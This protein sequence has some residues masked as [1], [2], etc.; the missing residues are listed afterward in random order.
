MLITI[1]FKDTDELYVLGDIIDRGDEPV[2]L[3]F[4]LMERPNVFPLMG[5]HEFTFWETI[6]TV[7][8]D[9]TVD[10]FM[11]YLDE[12]GL[13]NLSIMIADGGRVTLEQYFVLSQDDKAMFLDYI[14]EFALYYELTANKK[15]FLLTHSGLLNFN[16]E[17]DIDSYE[18]D[19]YLF[20]R[21]EYNKLF[22]RDKTIIFG[23]TPTMIYPE[24]PNPGKIIKS[25]TYINIDCGCGFRDR[26]GK[27]GCLRLE[28]M[29]EFYV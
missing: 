12:E 21:P 18:T 5:N 13:M 27:L 10:N 6:K 26:G 3:M 25:Q 9:A 8:I 11:K 20:D 23:H 2:K 4:D 17:N 22:Y 28:D 19:D 7:P 14:S 1:D 24:N 15:E 16:A 29:E